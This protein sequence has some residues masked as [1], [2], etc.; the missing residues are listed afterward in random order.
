[1]SKHHSNNPRP[2]KRQR[3]ENPP[4]W[5]QNHSLA[6]AASPWGTIQTPVCSSLQKEIFLSR[7]QRELIQPFFQQQEQNVKKKRRWNNPLVLLGVNQC[8]R[9][10]EKALNNSTNTTITTTITPSLIVLAR[11]IYPPTILS[12]IPVLAK[13]LQI[14]ILLLPGKASKEL[15]QAIGTQRTSILLF[16]QQEQDKPSAT[17]NANVPSFVQFVKET[18]LEHG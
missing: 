8:T 10:L 6:N 12:H 9:F 15:G 7:L 11:D 16:L 13:Q 14:P 5:L 3:K 1:M 2:T 4:S 17:D 18:L